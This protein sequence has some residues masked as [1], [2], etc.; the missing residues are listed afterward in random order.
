VKARLQLVANGEIARLEGIHRLASGELRDVEVY[1]GPVIVGGRRCVYAIVHDISER[2]RA[3]AAHRAA[4]EKLRA[5]VEQTITGF[6]MIEDGRFSYVNPRMA[7]IFG[8]SVAEMTGIAASTVV[9]P[10]DRAMAAENIRRRIDGEIDSLRFDVRGLRKD[11][12][13]IDV[14]VHGSATTIHGHRAI[15]GLVQDI[16]ERRKAEKRIKEYVRRLESA[17]VGTVEAISRMVDLRD[18]YTS[19]HE[20]RVAEIAAQIGR[21]LGLEEERVRGLQI[22]GRLH[23]IG[24]ISVPAEILSKPTRL[25]SMEFEIVKLHACHGHEILEGVEFPWPIAQ[26]AH[27]HHERMDGS[28]YPHGLKGDAIIPEA[29]IL[30]V[31]DVIEAMSSHR[32]YRASLGIEPALAEIERGAGRLYDGDAAN[33][34]LRLFRDKGYRLQD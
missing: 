11:G 23:D 34:A 24:K 7:E 1:C 33:A 8:Y 31:A 19:G 30:A 6:Y 9:A 32:P 10:E 25:T 17:M 22:A 26:I 28:G 27:Q 20:R 21:G 16:T 18:P 5:V 3:E 13:F 14:G 2:K 15:V 4:E 29:R 12:G